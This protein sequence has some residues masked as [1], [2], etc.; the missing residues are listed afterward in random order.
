MKCKGLSYMQRPGFGSTVGSASYCRSRVREFE[1]LPSYITD[2]EIDH[3][4]LVTIKPVFGV[5][6]QVIL[7]V[8]CSASETS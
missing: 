4:S 3:V 7:K 8:A 1:P 2:M 5:C 6:D